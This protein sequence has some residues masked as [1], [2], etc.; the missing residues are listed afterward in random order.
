SRGSTACARR[1]ADRRVVPVQLEKRR[2]VPQGCL[3]EG[4]APVSRPPAAKTRLNPLT[5]RMKMSIQTLKD[6]LPD[7]AKDLKLNLGSLAAET[8]LNDTLK[9]GTFVAAAFASR[10]PDVIAAIN[11]AVGHKLAPA[12]RRR[13]RGAA[14]V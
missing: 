9:A 6:R 8:A 14:T 11:A 2:R 1:V 5:R 13:D 3:T 12:H 7:Y 10:N 4:P